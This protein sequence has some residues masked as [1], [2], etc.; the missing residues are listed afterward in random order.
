MEFNDP[1]SNQSSNQLAHIHM[2]AL[3]CRLQ[4]Q[5]LPGGGGSPFEDEPNSNQPKSVLCVACFRCL[6]HINAMPMPTIKTCSEI[7]EG[8][9]FWCLYTSKI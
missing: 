4:S 2:H 6:Q 1:E 7:M 5:R 8:C 9:R 3:R